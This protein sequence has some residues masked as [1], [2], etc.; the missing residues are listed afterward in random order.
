MVVCRDEVWV[1]NGVFDGNFPQ[2]VRN[3]TSK[4]T[5]ENLSFPGIVTRNSFRYC[6]NF[7]K[8]LGWNLQRFAFLW[9]DDQRERPLR[10]MRNAD[11]AT[12]ATLC[13]NFRVAVL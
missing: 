4:R 11:A 1:T 12:H 8:R 2:P 13:V 3:K 5:L 7:S 9:C 6:L 10:T